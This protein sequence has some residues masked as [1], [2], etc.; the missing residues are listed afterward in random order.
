MKWAR[1][2]YDVIGT[3]MI[4]DYIVQR[5]AP[6]VGGN[7]A[8]VNVAFIPATKES[9]YSYISNM[10]FDSSANNTGSFFFRITARTSDVNQFWRSAILS[11]RSIDNIAPLMVSSFTATKVANNVLLNWDR[12]TAPDFLNYVL[13][14]S[15]SPTIDPETEPVFATTT[16][17]TYL[18]TAPL[19]GVHYYFIVA[20]DIHNNKSPVAIAE[21]PN[22][23]LN[24]TMFIEG[25]YDAQSN[26]QVSDTIEVELR[27]STSP[28]AIVDQSRAVMS[29]TGTVQLKFGNATNGSYYIAVKHRNSIETWSAGTIALSVTTPAN[30]DISASSSQAFGDNVRQVDSSPVRFAI[31]GGDVNQDGTIDATDVSTIGN[32]AIYFI[33][34]YVV[35]DLTGDDFVDGT[36]ISIADN[37]AANFVGAITP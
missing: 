20:Q 16:N 12:S 5:S 35:T 29:A 1:S 10:P 8:W 33:S 7:F 36:D 13:Y 17:M 22:M 15:T 6:P 25:F 21:S 9:F 24:L 2:S 3:N 32:D 19:S 26:L 28:F 18:D 23:T 34:G 11:G 37:N 31:Y 30:Y 4:T 14:R 27:N